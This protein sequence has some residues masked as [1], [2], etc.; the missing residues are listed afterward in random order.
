VNGANIILKKMDK[1][2]IMQ[3][4]KHNTNVYPMFR[5]LLEKQCLSHQG[6]EQDWGFSW[7]QALVTRV[8]AGLPNPCS[9]C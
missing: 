2:I 6:Y 8:P 9:M 7:V 4:E 5:I 3:V 1:A